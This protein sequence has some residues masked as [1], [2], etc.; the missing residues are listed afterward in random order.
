MWFEKF[1]NTISEVLHLDPLS[2]IDQEALRG[3]NP[4]KIYVENVR[5]LLGVSHGRAE[6]LCEAA[7]RRGI[8]TR[9][10][11]VLC[12]DGTVAASAGCESDLPDII[13]CWINEGG[14]H[15]EREFSTSALDKITFYRFRGSSAS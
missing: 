3:L 9:G 8:F 2:G 11:E 6:G 10:I 13:T 4:N 14:D 5:S 1:L 12:H 7:V 15:E